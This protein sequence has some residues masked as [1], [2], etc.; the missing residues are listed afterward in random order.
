MNSSDY[1]RVPSRLLLNLT[2]HHVLVYPADFSPF[3]MYPRSN[4]IA[5]LISKKQEHIEDLEDGCPV[6]TPQEFCDLVPSR[7]VLGEARGVIVSLMV[8]EYL[9]RNNMTDWAGGEVYCA[10]LS[11]EGCFKDETSGQILGTKRLTRIF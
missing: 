5:R 10:D 1:P 11:D 4:V 2:N 8:A 7:P 3:I 6:Y 9:K